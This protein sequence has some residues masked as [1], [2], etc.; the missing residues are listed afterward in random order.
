M[1]QWLD[2]L[3]QQLEG[4]L[5][6]REH[7]ASPLE[8]R[9]F[10]AESPW[11]AAS[12]DKRLLQ[13]RRQLEQAPEAAVQGL[14]WREPEPQPSR[15]AAVEATPTPAEAWADLRA[16]IEAPDRKSTRLNSSHSSVSRMPSSA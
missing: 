3:A 15:D 4:P 16:W 10:L 12:C 14:A 8:R 2:L 7:A 1:R 6:L 11:P 5:P 9:N 13:A